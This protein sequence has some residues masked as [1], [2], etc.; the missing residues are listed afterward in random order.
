MPREDG[1]TNA[2]KGR[3]KGSPNRVTK[4]ASLAVMA[5]FEK[6]GGVDAMVKWA[7]DH[8]DWFYIHIFGK[9]IKNTPNIQAMFAERMELQVNAVQVKDPREALSVLEQLED[10]RNSHRGDGRDSDQRALVGPVPTYP[11]DVPV[12][13]GAGAWA[14]QEAS[15]AAAAAAR[16]DDAVSE[17]APVPL[18]HAVPAA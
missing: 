1:L 17:A 13:D 15:D 7:Q 3:P 9:L 2:G 8:Q 6:M 5:V 4:E 12:P 16:Q 10:A 18:L 14:A 11:A